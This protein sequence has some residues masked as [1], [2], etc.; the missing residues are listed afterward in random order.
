MIMDHLKRQ[1]E[2]EAVR[3]AVAKLKA[4]ANINRPNAAH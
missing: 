4:D 3:D 2:V 1:S